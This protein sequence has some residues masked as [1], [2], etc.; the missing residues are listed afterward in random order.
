MLLLLL[1]GNI[2][3]ELL[4]GIIGACVTLI[5]AFYVTPFRN[6]QNS[7]V[8]TLH[9]ESV[10]R[11]K[12]FELASGSDEKMNAENI[13]LLVDCKFNPNFLTN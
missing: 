3:E 2:I 11:E 8:S 6:R 7:E 1:G 12:L 5:V 9:S 13:E 4:A 10:W